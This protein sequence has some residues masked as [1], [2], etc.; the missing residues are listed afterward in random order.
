MG[1]LLKSELHHQFLT[2]I[3]NKFYLLLVDFHVSLFQLLKL[4]AIAVMSLI[5]VKN[6]KILFDIKWFFKSNIST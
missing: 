3:L 5:F 4:L 6:K 1:T 2:H